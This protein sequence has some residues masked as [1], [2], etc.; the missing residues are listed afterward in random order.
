MKD[1]STALKHGR[2]RKAAAQ[3][4]SEHYFPCSEGTLANLA[5]SGEG[6]VYRLVAGK[7][8]YLDEDIDAWA[9][10]RISEPVRRASDLRRSHVGEAA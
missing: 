1:K 6:P 3:R 7:A 4:I 5:S 10:S 2:T 8:V 9:G